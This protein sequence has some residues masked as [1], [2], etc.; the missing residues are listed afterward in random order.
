MTVRMIAVTVLF[1]LV[2][3]APLVSASQSNPSD[4]RLL[5]E[6][7]LQ[8]RADELRRQLLV[9]PKL[10]VARE[11]RIRGDIQAIDTLLARLDAGET[12]SAVELA[13]VLGRPWAGDGAAASTSSEALAVR[14]EELERRLKLAPKLGARERVAIRQQIGELDELIAALERGEDVELARLDALLGR[15]TP[16]I[17]STPEEIREDLKVRKASM[18]QRLD[19]APKLG[20][21]ER[22]RIR[23]EIDAL[24]AMIEDLESR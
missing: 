13:A 8:Q 23:Q 12:P 9:A 15:A 17:A 5:V 20:I 3:G 7:S 18:R 11:A 10:G 14:Q 21:M 19:T 6:T 16:Q 2:I 22:E 24:D 4:D 1:S